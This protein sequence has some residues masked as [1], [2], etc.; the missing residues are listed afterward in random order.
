MEVINIVAISAM[1]FVSS[2]I[3][4]MVIAIAFLADPSYD[5]RNVL[6]GQILGFWVLTIVSIILAQALFII[7]LGSAWWLGFVPISFGCI[8]LL[9]YSS[10]DALENVEMRPNGR[11]I[12]EISML[13]MA[14]GA[15]EIIAYTPIFATRNTSEVVIL[16]IIF[17]IMTLLWW[18]MAR[19][20]V[21]QRAMRKFIAKGGPL[22]VS[23]LMIVIG[24]MIV[25]DR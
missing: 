10:R 20:L 16:L 6:L 18:L 24:I 3:D 12:R 25:F 9:N 7:P 19:W 17:I 21:R 22:L 13:T 4:G 23:V 5:D 15:D 14:T 8:K 1:A 11:Q 2:N